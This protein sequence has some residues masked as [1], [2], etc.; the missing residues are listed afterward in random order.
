M[1]GRTNK[2]RQLTQGSLPPFGREPGQI[3]SNLAGNQAVPFT[4]LQC[5]VTTANFRDKSRDV[6]RLHN[7]QGVSGK[8]YSALGVAAGDSI[9]VS[10]QIYRI[11]HVIVYQT[12][13]YIRQTTGRYNRLD[14]RPGTW[15]VVFLS[16]VSETPGP[17]GQHGQECN[18][19]DKM[20][21]FAFFRRVISVY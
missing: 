8:V 13:E 5:H 20:L 11:D 7:V 18:C 9:S 6:N 17:L 12:R 19:W 1:K 21:D 16:P 10:V 15:G 2:S 14:T 3:S 4:R